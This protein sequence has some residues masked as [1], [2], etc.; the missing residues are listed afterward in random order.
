MTSRERGPIWRNALHDA[1][2]GPRRAILLAE[3]ASL[4]SGS[5]DLVRASE[6]A[7]LAVVEASGDDAAR[8]RALEVASVIDMNLDTPGVRVSG[9][10]L[11]CRS[12]AG[13]AT[14]TGRLASSTLARWPRSWTPTSGWAQ[15]AGSRCA[16]FRRLR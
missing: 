6:L 15:A 2:S 12:S 16:S 1:R 13:S 10:Q 3:L 4:I 11:P 7:E 8:A 9:R 14:R 5:E